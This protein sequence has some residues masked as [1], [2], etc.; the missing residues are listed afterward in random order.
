LLDEDT[1]VAT[2]RACHIAVHGE[3]KEWAIENNFLRN[4]N[5]D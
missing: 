4:K 5:E 3:Y 1:W 2:C